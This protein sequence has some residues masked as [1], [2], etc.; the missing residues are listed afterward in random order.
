MPYAQSSLKVAI[1]LRGFVEQQL[2]QG[3]HELA[4]MHRARDDLNGDRGVL[5][6]NR[7]QKSVEEF[8]VIRVLH[9]II[10]PIVRDTCMTFTKTKRT[11]FP[12]WT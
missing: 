11:L 2:R 6:T 10:R 5:R 7:K 12:K 1:V 9:A 3:L 8:G 4:E